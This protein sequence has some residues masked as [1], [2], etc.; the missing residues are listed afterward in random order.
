ML[1]QLNDRTTKAKAKHGGVYSVPYVCVCVP[2]HLH[3]Q[4]YTTEAEFM[5][6]V[7]ISGII[8]RVLRLDISV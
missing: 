6:D 4:E 3:I 2:V 7:E 8:L 5:N 1:W